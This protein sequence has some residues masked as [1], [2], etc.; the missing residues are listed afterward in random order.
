[1]YQLGHNRMPKMTIPYTYRIIYQK[2]GKWYYGVRYAENCSPDDLWVKYF[3]S[4]KVVRMLIAND[5][6]AAFKVEIRR[7]FLTKEEAIDWER[8]VLKKVFKWDNCLNENC[9]P[10]VTPEA[11]SRGNHTKAK[12][13]SSGLTIFQ[14][15]GQKWKAKQ[16]EISPNGKTYREIRNEKFNASLTK[17]GTRYKPKQSARLKIDN[18]SFRPEVR[19]SIANSLKRCYQNGYNGTNGKKM[20]KISEMLIGNTIAKDSIWVTNGV[21]DKRVFGEVPDGYTLG[22]ASKTIFNYALQICPW[23][24]TEGRGGNMKRYHF[25]N[26]KSSPCICT[27]QVDDLI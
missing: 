6:L 10:A 26:C 22:R 16:D 24:K 3:T 14:I 7:T 15:A 25:D 23:C 1:M 4:S 5:G 11:R 21:N 8:R 18:P 20:P 13:Q 12:V 9:F 19:E 17:N 2:S 27:L